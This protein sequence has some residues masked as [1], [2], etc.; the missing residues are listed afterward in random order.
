LDNSGLSNII[1]SLTPD[2]KLKVHINSEVVKSYATISLKT[3]EIRGYKLLTTDA[4]L[5]HKV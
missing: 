4:S 3:A 5:V 2:I 1:N